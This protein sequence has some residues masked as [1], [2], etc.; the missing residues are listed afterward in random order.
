MYVTVMLC[1][2]CN[3]YGYGYGW[4]MQVEKKLSQM[5]LDR[6]FSGILEQGK[7]HL[8]VYDSASEDKRCVQMCT[9][10]D[11]NGM[12]YLDCRKG[13]HSISSICCHSIQPLSFCNCTSFLQHQHHHHRHH[14]YHHHH[15]QHYQHY[16]HYQLCSFT[17]GSEII[18]NMESVVAALFARAKNMTHKTEIAAATNG[19]GDD[20]KD[21]DSVELKK[22][23][24]E[25]KQ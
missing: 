14:H 2:V 25:K 8:V 20:S 19:N 10:S 22:T 1:Y 18:G 24:E 17:H 13:S 12:I 11:L 23:A 9:T 21:K 6:T 5:I 7:G 16:Q 4:M 15:H 3:G